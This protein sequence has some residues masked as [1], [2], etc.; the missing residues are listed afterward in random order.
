LQEQLLPAGYVVARTSVILTVPCCAILHMTDSAALSESFSTF[1]ISDELID[2][3]LLNNWRK[4]F[5]IRPSHSSNSSSTPV[6][7][8]V[9]SNGTAPAAGLDG[10]HPFVMDSKMRLDMLALLPA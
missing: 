7:S 8:G 10:P 5:S 6:F 2:P 4:S 1:A 9:C 3:S